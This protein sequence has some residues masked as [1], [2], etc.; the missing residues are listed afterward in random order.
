MIVCLAAVHLIKLVLNI[1]LRA[2]ILLE[3]VVRM[4]DS[5]VQTLEAYDNLL[6]VG[7][8]QVQGAFFGGLIIVLVGLV[9]SR[10]ALISGIV[11][12][13]NKL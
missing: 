5:L 1:I 7:A 3:G 12:N 10:Q 13:R 2:F 11:P 9:C 8:I 4:P 6:T